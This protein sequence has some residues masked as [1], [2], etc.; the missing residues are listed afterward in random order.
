M[1]IEAIGWASSVV[2]VLTIGTQVYTQWRDDTSKGVSPWLFV[3]EVV[4]SAGF[5]AYSFII[6]NWVFVVTNA[7]L[8]IYGFLGLAIY[9][10]HKRRGKA[11]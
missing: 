6:G 11:G 1:T 2:L 5:C 9:A 10:H 3:G 7:M 4:A 8:T